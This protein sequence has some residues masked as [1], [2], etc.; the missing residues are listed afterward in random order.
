ERRVE[1]RIG[2]VRQVDLEILAGV[3]RVAERGVTR[4]SIERESG[5]ELGAGGLVARPLAFRL[6]GVEGRERLHVGRQAE[7]FLGAVE[8]RRKR[9]GGNRDGGEEKKEGDEAAHG[10]PPGRSILSLH[11]DFRRPSWASD[12]LAAT[13]DLESHPR[14]LRKKK[15]RPKPP[16][17]R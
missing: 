9:G 1:R 3:V 10:K 15:G 13:P 5:R 17:R 6:D 12:R 2:L 4:A 7:L 11:T 16:L 8:E 14:R